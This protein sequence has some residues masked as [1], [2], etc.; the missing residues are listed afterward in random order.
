MANIRVF[1][2]LE[3]PGAVGLQ[4]A[5]VAKDL[6]H[7]DQVRWVR[8]EGVHLTLKFLG[9]IDKRILPKVVDVVKQVTARFQPLMLATADLGAFPKHDKAQVLW[10]G[11][12]GDIDL[13]KTLQE[14]ID[15]ALE[16]IGFKPERRK[17]KA[18]ITVGRVRR[19]PV[20]IDKRALKVLRPIHFSID[21]V[22]VMK[23]DLHPDGAVYTPMGYG[24]LGGG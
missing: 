2:A 7:L 17:F 5:E 24:L 10:L 4:V 22:S 14:Q 16:S 11:V 19:K 8:Q 12:T 1:V 15:V 9:D 21:R 13:L 23:S 18:H 20:K 3:L 6:R